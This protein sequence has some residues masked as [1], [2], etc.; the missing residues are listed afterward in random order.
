METLIALAARRT[1]EHPD[2][3]GGYKPSAVLG[4]IVPAA[5][6][7]TLAAIT[8]VHVIRTRCLWWGLVLPIGCAFTALG[9]VLKLWQRAQMEKIM[10]YAIQ[11]LFVLVSP[12]AFLAWN[13]IICEQA[14]KRIHCNSFADFSPRTQLVASC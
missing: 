5:V 12:A 4:C 1:A 6:Y 11:N 3:I 10:P 13:Y 9:F 8:I 2:W 14:L 7:G